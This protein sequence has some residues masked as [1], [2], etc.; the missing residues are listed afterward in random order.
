MLKIFRENKLAVILLVASFLAAAGFTGAFFLTGGDNLYLFLVKVTCL[1]W[2]Y[3]QARAF[4]KI[5]I[6]YGLENPV[7]TRV[8]KLLKKIF[9]G[10][11]AFAESLGAKFALLF[12]KLPRFKLPSLPKRKANRLIFFQDEK[13]RIFSAKKRDQFRKM[14]WKN[15]NHRERVRFIYISFLRGKIKKGAIVLPNETPNELAVKLA[16]DTRTETLFSLYNVARYAS[17]ETS[18]EKEEVENI[19]PCASKRLTM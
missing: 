2:F 8:K 19:L 10:V 18:V 15:L 17:A 9:G 1:V 3:F 4:V 7:K 14:K 11:L 16:N 6:Q 5:L 12:A 13:A